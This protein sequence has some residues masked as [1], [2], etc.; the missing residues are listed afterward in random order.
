[1]TVTESATSPCS[2]QTQPRRPGAGLPRLGQA[3][4]FICDDVR[5][6]EGV[7]ASVRQG[8]PRVRI[9][10]GLPLLLTSRRYV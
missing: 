2:S 3:A 1:M 10:L 5:G 8:C 9:N 7:R 4:A 6:R